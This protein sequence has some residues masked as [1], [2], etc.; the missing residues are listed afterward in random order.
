MDLQT[1]S[2]KAVSSENARP[3]N[4]FRPYPTRQPSSAVASRTLPVAWIFPNGRDTMLPGPETAVGCAPPKAD[5]VAERAGSTRRRSPAFLA[6]PRACVTCPPSAYLQ[7]GRGL[8]KSGTVQAVQHVVDGARRSLPGVGHGL[9][10]LVHA[11]GVQMEL[12]DKEVVGMS[13]L[14]VPVGQDFSGKSLRLNVARA[15]IAAASTCRSSGSGRWREPMSGWWPVTTASR[16][17][18]F[19]S[20]RVRCSRPSSRSGRL[21]CIDRKVSSG[22]VSLHFA[23]MIRR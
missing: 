3:A 11:D 7:D 9:D 19:I 13:G 15:R 14:D 1:L 4:N 20:S 17:A 10:G 21:A 16:T 12:V 23:W 5:L 6:R 18:R 22:I 2:G 8:R